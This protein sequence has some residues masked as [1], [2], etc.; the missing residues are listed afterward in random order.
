MKKGES[1]D[2]LP[3]FCWTSCQKITVIRLLLRH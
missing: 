1:V 2:F 3:S